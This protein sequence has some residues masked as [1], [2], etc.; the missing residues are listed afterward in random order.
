MAETVS[1]IQGSLFEDG[2]LRRSIKNGITTNPETAITEL[3]AN[4]WDAG[5]TEVDITIPSSIGN[6]LIISDNG[7]GM[8]REE[9]FERWMTL[10]YNRAAHQ[11][12]SIKDP[13]ND[14]LYRL[15]Y[16]RNGEGRHGLLCFGDLYTVKTWKDGTEWTFVVSARE[17][18]EALAILKENSRK[19]DGQGTELSVA[20]ESNLPDSD[21]ISQVISSRFIYDPQFVIKVNGNVLQIDDLEGLIDTQSLVSDDGVNMAA[22]LVRTTNSAKRGGYQ[23]I[24]FWQ[25]GRLIG[26]PSWRLGDIYEIDGRTVTARR[27]NVIVQSREF[28]DIIHPDWSGFIRGDKTDNVFKA[29]AKYVNEVFS[30]I[31]KENINETKLDIEKDLKKEYSEASPIAR[32]QAEETIEAILNDAPTTTKDTIKTAVKAVLN[33]QSSSEGEEL[34]RKLSSM[35]VTDIAELNRILS[36]WNVKD[37][38]KVLDVIDRRLTVIELINKLSEDPNTDELHVLH[39]LITESRWVFGPEFDSPEYTANQQVRTITKK[40]FQ[41][42]AYDTSFNLSKRP[43]LVVLQN[44]SCY[45]VTGTNRFENGITH[46]DHVLIVEL[47][48]GHFKITF[49]E[50]VQLQRYVTMILQQ[51]GGN[52]K[53]TSF[54]LGYD[55]DDGVVS[56]KVDGG[57]GGI[58]IPMKF[59][60]L[61]DTADKRM[62]NLR[63]QLTSMYEDVPGVELYK[64]YEL[65]MK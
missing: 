6:L 13:A 41:H 62:M 30:R 39:P 25:A 50:F 56:T 64:Q 18:K 26:S 5:A 17:K 8:T 34:L 65:K 14:S 31:S 19:K 23:G 9:F 48:K 33:L 3:V 46:L 45:S 32:I 27:Y 55:I 49:E 61:I 57:G 35:S 38:M 4:A 22:S 52:I 12:N 63:E 51:E 11:N 1:Y 16:G 20:V 47:K 58:V 43:D 54:I 42:E 2:F 40:L 7:E 60:Q 53:V 10:S 59:S 15:A 44:G 29:V 24:A 36:R 28:A 37:A 21:R